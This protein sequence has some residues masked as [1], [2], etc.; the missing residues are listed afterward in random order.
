MREIQAQVNL[1]IEG[2]QDF[3]EL[4]RTF[5]ISIFRTNEFF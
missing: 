4:E 5:M 3:F 1:F 2:K